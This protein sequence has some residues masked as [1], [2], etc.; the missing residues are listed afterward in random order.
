MPP[1]NGPLPDFLKPPPKTCQNHPDVLADWECDSCHIC[2]CKKCV[3]VRDYGDFK[4]ETC[5]KCGG[6]C[7][8]VVRS[9]AGPSREPGS[10]FRL[11]PAAFVYPFRGHGPW[12]L[13]GFVAFWVVM[14]IVSFVAIIGFFLGVLMLAYLSRYALDLIRSSAN[15]DPDPPDWPDITDLDDTVR[16]LLFFL[17][18]VGI[19]FAPTAVYYFGF[20]Q[21]GTSG[22]VWFWAFVGLGTLLVPMSLLA[23]A[24]Y[25]SILAVNPVIV[26][27]A[28]AKM[29]VHYVTA[30]AFMGLAIVLVFAVGAIP[31]AGWI[32]RVFL[33][34]YLLMVEM[35]IIGLLYYTHRKKLAWF[36]D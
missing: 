18:T 19:C 31:Y 12:M 8:A 10:F 28:I 36:D 14:L 24:L 22:D 35:R 17:G 33:P 13:L 26:F 21:K 15:G 1:R 27:R 32:L 4:L 20:Y 2:F 7:A 9:A 23:V 30:C 5:K 6:R 34:L 29:P 25:D 3:N 16:D 11:V